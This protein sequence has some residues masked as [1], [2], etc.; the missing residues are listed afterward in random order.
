MHG[1]PA[2]MRAHACIAA[3]AIRRHPRAT[4]GRLLHRAARPRTG[5]RMRRAAPELS[6]GPF[7][8]A[9]LASHIPAP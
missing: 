7:G 3:G 8:L 4:H 5:S 2:T 6:G 1:A 9:A